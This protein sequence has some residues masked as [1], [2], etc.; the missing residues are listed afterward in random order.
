MSLST[1]DQSLEG[2]LLSGIKSCHIIVNEFNQN[3]RVVML[4]GETHGKQSC[5]ESDYITAY[6]SFLD[7][8]EMSTQ[9]PIDV[10]LEDSNYNMILNRGDTKWIFEL[11]NT[12]QDCYV[13]RSRD[14]GNCSFKHV[15]FHW[16]DP[17][18]GIPS[19]MREVYE[20]PP[21]I[22]DD[23]W[24]HEMEYSDIADEIESEDDLE[25]IIF[26]NPHI[27]SISLHWR[28]LLKHKSDIDTI[29]NW[30]SSIGLTTKLKTSHSNR[31][32]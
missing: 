1:V 31:W 7:Y 9:V 30:L 26:E 28:W 2:P 29:N 10:L 17:Q 22:S 8:N 27:K 5:G 3:P 16:T 24:M 13:A 15:R 4:I 23:N 25:K 20:L 21:F 12:F 19:W 32:I 6:K 11:R 18:M 14:A